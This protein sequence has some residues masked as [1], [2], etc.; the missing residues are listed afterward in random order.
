MN[1]LRGPRVLG[2][3]R[4]QKMEKQKKRRNPA[5][6]C[7]MNCPA[8]KNN[9]NKKNKSSFLV[10]AEWCFC[11]GTGRNVCKAAPSKWTTENLGVSQLVHDLS[12]PPART[13]GRNKK[14][15][16]ILGIDWPGQRLGG[17][18]GKGTGRRLLHVQTTFCREKKSRFTMRPTLAVGKRQRGE[19]K[20]NKLWGPSD[21]QLLTV[22]NT[23]LKKIY[24][25]I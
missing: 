3:N 11:C 12:S 22:R 15:T 2:E 4:F 6:P 18:S 19:R 8:K 16:P 17:P 1:G 13:F 20:R 14:K 10:G 24:S 9:N 7:R 5:A 25:E 21:P 23:V